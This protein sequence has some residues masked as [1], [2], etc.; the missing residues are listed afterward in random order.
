MSIRSAID[1]ANLEKARQAQGAYASGDI[2]N[3]PLAL[4]VTAILGALSLIASL[5]S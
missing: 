2:G 5:F 1:A 4:I 3:N